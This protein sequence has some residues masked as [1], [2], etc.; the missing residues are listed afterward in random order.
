M[1]QKMKYA[2]E[3]AWP[4]Y[5]QNLQ[6]QEKGLDLTWRPWFANPCA[7]GS[8]QTLM[9]V[10]AEALLWFALSMDMYN[11][12]SRKAQMTLSSP[13]SSKN[14]SQSQSVPV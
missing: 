9:V 7:R 5:S 3:W 1:S 8:V 14:G 6:K 11:I 2:H 10:F 13:C 12:L 4:C